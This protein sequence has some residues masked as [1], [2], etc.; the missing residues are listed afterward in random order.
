[1]VFILIPAPLNCCSNCFS[2]N[3]VFY[4]NSYEGYNQKSY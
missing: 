3:F 2:Y 4:L 1:M